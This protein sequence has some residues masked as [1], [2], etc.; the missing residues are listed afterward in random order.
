MNGRWF[1]V[2]SGEGVS[3]IR[4]STLGEFRRLEENTGRVMSP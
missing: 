2:A 4:A 3:L 1:L